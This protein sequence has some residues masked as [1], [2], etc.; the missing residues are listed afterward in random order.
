ML[1][2]L[3]GQRRGVAPASSSAGSPP[4]RRPR[5]VAQPATK[6][7]ARPLVQTHNCDGT[8][9]QLWVIKHIQCH[10]SS[11]AKKPMMCSRTS[12]KM[13]PN[14]AD[15]VSGILRCSEDQA[16]THHTQGGGSTSE[17]RIVPTQYNILPLRHC[18]QPKMIYPRQTVPC[19][20]KTRKCAIFAPGHYFSIWRG[21]GR[22]WHLRVLLA[23]QKRPIFK[24][25]TSQ[26]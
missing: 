3:G 7:V 12:S 13:A 15:A 11:N 26:S 8:Y 24:M 1:A 22:I 25:Y 6:S 23:G 10:N 2:P 14:T 17:K 20:A 19:P 21:L 4:L 18:V 16:H 5:D 9:E